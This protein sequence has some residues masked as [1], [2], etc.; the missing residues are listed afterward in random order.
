MWTFE[1]FRFGAENRWWKKIPLLLFSVLCVSSQAQNILSDKAQVSLLTCSPSDG[2]VYTLYG[3]TAL[4]VRDTTGID[5]VFNY[6][7]FDFSKPNFIYRFTKGE[8]DYMLGVNRYG[9][10][11]IDYQMRGSE[12][13]E[14]VLNLR[15]DEKN[16][17][18]R[19]LV[20]NAQPENCVYR[21]SFFYDNCSTRPAA[22]VARIVAGRVEYEEYVGKTTFREAINRCTRNHPWLTFGCDLVL[23]MPADRVMTRE[24]TFFLPE[25]VK[26]V[27]ARARIVREGGVSTPLV[28][29]AAAV[30]DAVPDDEPDGEPAHG[31]FTPGLCA[32]LIFALAAGVTIAERRAKKYFRWFDMLLFTLAGLAG[33]ILYF[34]CFVSVH[35]GIWPNISVVWLHPFHLAGVMCFAVKKLNKAAYYYHCI[36]FAALLVMSAGWIFVPQHL[37]AAFVPLIASLLLRSGYGWTRIKESMR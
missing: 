16:A 36:N 9:D 18:F 15:T 29:A 6:G 33:C 22:L 35:R 26:N 28:S 23:G 12:V 30:V 3:H 34:L 14:Q 5:Y 20:V 31:A 10:F 4:R 19:A 17:L 32:G 8:T 7:L 24:E 27:F 37:N 1:I 21:Y 11:L 13:Y 2:T 25:N